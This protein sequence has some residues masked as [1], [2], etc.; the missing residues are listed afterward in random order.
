MEQIR[1]LSGETISSGLATRLIGG[2]ETRIGG[3]WFS[4]TALGEL[5]MPRKKSDPQALL[6][7]FE[8]LC[9]KA[10]S[11]IQTQ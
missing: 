3:Q 2:T 7:R 5:L 8:A 11:A 6:A 1:D 4:S 9:K 10:Y